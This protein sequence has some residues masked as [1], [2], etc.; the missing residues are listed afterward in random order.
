MD[1]AAEWAAAN[2]KQTIFDADPNGWAGKKAAYTV[3][4]GGVPQVDYNPDSPMSYSKQSAP[5][6][7]YTP[8]QDQEYFINVS[9][10]FA[11]GCSGDAF[12]VLESKTVFLGPASDNIFAMYEYPILTSP[13]GVSKIWVVETNS[14]GTVMTT[15][16][17][18]PR[19]WWSRDCA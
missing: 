11:Q 9:K 17:M 13:G 19:V 14:A 15:P 6:G 1:Q 7:Q 10:A 4:V 2:G 12:L 18:S 8:A 3:T 16:R 5:G